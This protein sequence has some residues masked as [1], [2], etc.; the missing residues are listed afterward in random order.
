MQDFPPHSVAFITGAASGIGLATA[1]QLVLDGVLNIALVDI[2]PTI[3]ATASSSLTSLAPSTRLLPILANCTQ[4]SEVDA[5]VEKTLDH[6]GHLDFAVNAA[7]ISGASRLIE[8]M[9]LDELD[10]VMNLNLRGVWLCE[11]AEVK[12]MM[13]REERGLVNGL[14][15]KT[16]GSI[17]NISSIMGITSRISKLAPY[18][19]AK[20]GVIGLTKSVACD[21]A[22][23]GIRVNSIS[24]GWIKT[25]INESVHGNP[26]SSEHVMK[27]FPMGRWGVPE[28]V[29]Y[30]ISF[31][32]SDR[33]SF[34]TGSNH[35]IDGGLTAQ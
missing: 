7:G 4:E 31:L 33:A 8:E 10:H 32:L 2:N 35:V 25:A 6:F 18:T 22:Q 17:V 28:E 24:P 15:F 20:H 23:K 12:A 34:I 9:S 1:R 30:L 11:R 26:A 19:M 16:R 14:P 27:S 5:A 29:A 21:Y 3:L 13:G